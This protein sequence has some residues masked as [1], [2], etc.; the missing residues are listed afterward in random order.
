MSDAIKTLD[1]A[2]QRGMSLRPQV[3]GFPYLA[4]ALREA[5]VTRNEWFLPSCQSLYLM[6]KGAVVV[7]NP[8][9]ISGVIDIP[10][11][12]QER[13]IKAL[14]EDQAGK[15]S[16]PEFLQATWEAGVVRYEVDFIARKVTYYG[17][18][19]LHL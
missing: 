4:E 5:G 16:F 19:S 12:N 18:I 6:G 17:C 7:Q 9:L 15:T 2:I 10:P 8:P 13:L 11:F 1:A 3:G 14:R